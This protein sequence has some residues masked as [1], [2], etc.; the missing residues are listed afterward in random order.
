[1]T[2]DGLTGA[3]LAR[4]FFTEVVDPI[5]TSRFAGL[6]FAAARVGTGSDVLGFDDETS[7][8]HDWGVRLSVFVPADVVASVDGELAQRLPESF[9]GYP[10]RF[11]FTGER[12][13]RHH[14]EVTSVSDF[15]VNRLGFDPRRGVTLA[16]WLSVTGQAVL[17]LTAGP[18]FADRA[19]ELEELRR[20]LSW[21]PDDVWRYVLACDWDRIDQELPLMSRAADVG[22]D[23][24]SRIIA[25]RLV[26]VVMHLAFMLERRWPPYAKWFGSGFTQLGVAEAVTGAVAAAVTSSDARVRQSSI[27]RALDA[28]LAQQNAL[29]L[30]TTG[31]ATVPFWNRPYLHP[32]P[33]IVDQLIA[34]IEDAEVRRLP[35]GRG[36]IEQLTDNVRVLVDPSARRALVAH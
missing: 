12:E 28:L 10:T 23:P 31:A 24:G 3:E 32:D 9:N 1:V 16:D 2:D 21:Y 29:G 17:E 34:G 27:A 36:S 8:D 30:T 35:R 4:A 11:A 15:A 13:S 6:P 20:A 25:A 19:A 18:V 14:V 22:D 26:H 33:Q 5:L 7:R